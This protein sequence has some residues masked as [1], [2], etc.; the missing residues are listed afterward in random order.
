MED[1]GEDDKAQE[2]HIQ[3]LPIQVRTLVYELWLLNS[4]SLFFPPRN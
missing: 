3:V 4:E 1:D 2:E